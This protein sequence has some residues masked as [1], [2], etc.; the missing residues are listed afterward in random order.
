MHA[1]AR[2]PGALHDAHHGLLNGIL[3]PYV[4]RQNRRAIA[5]QMVKLARHLD[6]KSPGFDGVLDWVL[7]LRAEI[8]IPH[9]LEEIGIGD[10]DIERVRHM[11]KMD[12]AA[13]G[14]P[15]RLGAAQ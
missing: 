6:L 14:N 8:G 1:L 3:M 12:A 2:S 9:S 11:A 4:L 7:A 13:A 10:G 5:P 15:V